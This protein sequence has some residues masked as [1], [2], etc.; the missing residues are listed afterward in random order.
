MSE[1]GAQPAL[2][3]AVQNPDENPLLSGRNGAAVFL[4][5]IHRNVTN[6]TLSFQVV[7]SDCGKGH[8]CS[9]SSDCTEY[10]NLTES[11][12]W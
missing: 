12:H 10:L 9:C 8:C 2:T 3:E 5:S 1:H 6:N 4:F 11:F 7:S